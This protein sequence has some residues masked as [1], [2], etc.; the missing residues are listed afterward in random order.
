MGK[1]WESYEKGSLII[2]RKV[3]RILMEFSNLPAWLKE[4]L[5][6]CL[7][8]KIAWEHYE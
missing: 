6:T 8:Y 3:H 5:P 1:M 2:P 7:S 4:D